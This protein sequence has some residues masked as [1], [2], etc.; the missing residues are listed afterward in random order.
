[1]AG[2]GFELKRIFKKD[3]L[4]SVL[5]GAAYSTVVVIGP[6]II[7]M[8]TLLVLYGAL[9]FM[10]VIYADRELLSS[11]ILYIF[12]FALLI[13]A[14][15]NAVM[16][17][18]IADRIF[19]EQYEDILPSF[20]TG[21]IISELAGAVA[22]LL[23]AVRLV[24][25]GEVELWFVVLSYLFFME[26]IAVF[27]ALTYLTATKDY[28]IVAS[29]FLIGML[30]AF[31][32]ALASN[33]VFGCRIIYAILGGMCFGFWVIGM[34][35]FAYIRHFFSVSNKNYRGCLHYFGDLKALF[36]GTLFYTLG[37]YVHNF[38]FWGTSGHLVIAESFYSYQPYDM[39]ACLGMFTNISAMVIFTVMAETK[40]HDI[41]Q[42]YNEAIIGATLKDIE[43]AKK[44]MFRLLIQQIGYVVRVQAIISVIIFLLA[45]IFL[46]DYGF[47]GLEMTIYPSLAAAFFGIFTMYCN[48]IFLYYFND[49][50][51]TFYTG[52][53]FFIGTL[54]GSL[55]A[56]HFEPQFYG[57]GA[58][59]GALIG[60]SFSYFR[61]RY[62]EKHFDYHIMCSMHVIKARRTKKPD[63][64]VYRRNGEKAE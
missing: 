13:T 22:G 26:L 31:L 54:I 19:E 14:P 39:A 63:A 35:Q 41:Y 3:S 6:T 30:A 18:Y 33:K 37:L 43:L 11:A 57:I 29:D 52:L 24:L 59:F 53:I 44:N 55:A 62:L 5:S 21:L 58:L 46:P 17:R 28:K 51:G 40:F 45:V 42:S 34:L 15:I 38:V 23:F 48:I 32:L 1:M 2:I 20:Y 61:I 8:A 7:V 49:S 27:Y 12:V 50:R 4:I 64:V 60:W 36:F 9:G 56:T 25:V 16:S 10:E 47:S